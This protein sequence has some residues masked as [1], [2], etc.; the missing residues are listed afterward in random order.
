MSEPALSAETPLPPAVEAY[1]RADAE[2]PCS[3][4]MPMPDAGYQGDAA[5][6]VLAALVDC[7]R[8]EAKRYIA[9][10]QFIYYDRQDNR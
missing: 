5:R 6:Y 1:L 10:D 7:Y 4:G 2:Y 3:D 9:G 8:D